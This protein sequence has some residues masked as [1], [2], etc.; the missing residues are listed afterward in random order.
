[1]VIFTK[2]MFLKQFHILCYLISDSLTATI[3]IVEQFDF[4]SSQIIGKENIVAALQR[5]SVTL[6]LL[7]QASLCLFLTAGQISHNV[8]KLIHL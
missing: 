7:C 6:L 5:D 2:Y 4:F 3:R 8:V 1:M